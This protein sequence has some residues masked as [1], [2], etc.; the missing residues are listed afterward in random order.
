[1][2]SAVP[3]LAA[4]VSMVLVANHSDRSG[5]RRWHVALPALAGCLGLA[6][7]AYFLKNNF[8]LAAFFALCLAASGIWSTL[9]PFW[10]MPTAFLSGTAAAGGIALVNSVGNLGGFVGPYV[11]GYVKGI[12]GTFTSGLLVLAATLLVAGALALGRTE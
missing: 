3:Y 8:P 1:L 7:S 11:I 4:S 9:G 12:T 10:S 5:E 6:L 2:I